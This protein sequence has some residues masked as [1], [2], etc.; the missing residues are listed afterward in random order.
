MVTESTENWWLGRAS[1]Q[2]VRTGYEAGAPCFGW[3]QWYG[4]TFH[5]SKRV[6]EC[7]LRQGVQ[8]IGTLYKC[9]VFRYRECNS[10]VDIAL[11]QER[12]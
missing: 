6:S 12:Q 1:V 9:S 8:Q 5:V 10:R 4:V 2:I 7:K 11:T 3:W